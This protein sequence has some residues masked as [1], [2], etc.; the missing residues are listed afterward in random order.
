MDKMIFIAGGITA[1]VGIGFLITHALY[2]ALSPAYDSG[3][4]AGMVVGV[5]MMIWGKRLDTKKGAE[6]LR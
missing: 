6:Q 1:A 3:G 4:V 5:G 2:P